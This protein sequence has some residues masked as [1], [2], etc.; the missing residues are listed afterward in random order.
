MKKRALLLLLF[1][2]A[3]AV[4]ACASSLLYAFSSGDVLLTKPTQ[5]QIPTYGIGR[6]DFDSET[7]EMI[8]TVL[9]SGDTKQHS[10][11]EFTRNGRRYIYDTKV[12]KPNED[13]TFYDVYD[14]SRV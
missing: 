14:A 13:T 10:L 6:I 11:G 12:Q 8:P 1:L 9:I 2:L 4:P 5:S 7:G 3:G